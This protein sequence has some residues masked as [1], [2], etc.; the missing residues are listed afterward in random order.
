MIWFIFGLFAGAMITYAYSFHVKN[1]WNTVRGDI[2][3]NERRLHKLVENTKDCLYYFETKPKWRYTYVYPSLE[4]ILGEE[5]GKLAYDQPELML[6]RCHPDD[7]DLLIKKING[8]VDYSKPIIYR[9]ANS[10]GEYITFEEYTTPVYKDG[11]VVAIQGI[12]RNITDKLKLQEELEYRSDH[13]S[14]TGVYNRGYFD[15]LLE[16]YNETEDVPVAILIIDLDNLKQVNDQFGHKQGDQL[17]KVAAKL[18]NATSTNDVIVSRI[19]GDEFAILMTNTSQEQVKELVE[20]I[21]ADVVESREIEIQMS[22]GYAF[23]ERSI[24]NMESL[25]VEADRMMYEDKLRRKSRAS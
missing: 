17:I 13:D 2:T 21:Q 4:K 1:S 10:Q 25:Y 8:E 3:D 5:K 22:I 16:K 18:L 19:G 23:N 7:Y 11:E 20:G 24:G 12:L 9:I 14:L 15:G 6:E